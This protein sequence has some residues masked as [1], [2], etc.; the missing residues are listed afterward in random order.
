MATSASPTLGI[1]YSPAKADNGARHA[2]KQI[3]RRGYRKLRFA[4][5]DPVGQKV[6]VSVDMPVDLAAGQSTTISSSLSA[7]STKLWIWTLQITISDEF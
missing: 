5:I 6:L 4:V 1:K 7:P 2:G 3:Q